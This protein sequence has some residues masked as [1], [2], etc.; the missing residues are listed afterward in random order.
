MADI[1]SGHTQ[2]VGDLGFERPAANGA[3]ACM[4]MCSNHLSCTFLLEWLTALAC[5]VPN[6]DVEAGA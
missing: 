6:R 1:L 2:L 4:Q 3:P 5:S